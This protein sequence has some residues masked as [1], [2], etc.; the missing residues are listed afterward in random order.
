[1]TYVLRIDRHATGVRVQVGQALDLVSYGGTAQGRET[2]S[3]MAAR[4]GAIAAINGDFF[5]FNG[6][7]TSLEIRDGELMS[8]PIGYRVAVGLTRDTA[9]V[10]ILT[11]RGTIQTV[12]KTEILLNGINHLPHEAETVLLTSA[13]APAAK[14]K[15]PSTVVIL[16]GVTLPFH[17]SRD[18]TGTVDSVSPLPA[19]QPLPP[20]PKDSVLIVGSGTASAPLAAHCMV[21]D[22][23]HLRYDLMAAAPVLDQGGA[24]PD[25]PTPVWQDVEQAIGGGPWLV[26]DG[27]IFVDGDAERLSPTDFVNARHARSA[28]GICTDGSLLLVA[29]DGRKATSRGVTLP[30]MAVILKRLGAQQAINLDG[31]G[32]TAMVVG[33]SIVNSPSD[34]KER[35][36]AN[37]LLLFANAP[38]SNEPPSQPHSP[39]APSSSAP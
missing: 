24:A 5:P 11:S 8:E 20:C 2:M 13:Y 33:G 18:L 16:K 17:V 38:K 39:S 30:E 37:G 14:P 26:R 4:T 15:Q 19:D 27:K 25:V 28:I 3:H 7:P 29:V 35:P 32:S 21:G 34:G 9:V 22:T 1:M 31:G 12:D 6:D 36:V 23:V 10:Q